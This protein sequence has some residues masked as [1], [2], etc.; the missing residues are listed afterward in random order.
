MI[1]VKD[2]S[3]Y[4]PFFKKR[5]FDC[6]ATGE[7][8]MTVRFMD[9]IYELRK[10]YGKPVNISSGYRSK[11]HPIE[12]SKA[13]PG[14]HALGIAA[15]ITCWSDEAFHIVKIAMELGF[16]GIGVSQ[17]RNRNERFI[18]IDLRDDPVLYSY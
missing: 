14:N 10:R 17:S 11:R 12:A 3:K 9:L 4:K 15:D 7:N 18:H 5:E 16:T 2:W 1:V 6:K 8:E 13:T